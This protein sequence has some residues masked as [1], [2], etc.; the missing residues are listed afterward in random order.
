L[1]TFS[2]SFSAVSA[3]F[4]EISIA[5]GVPQDKQALRHSDDIAQIVEQLLKVRFP[6]LSS[7]F[8]ILTLPLFAAHS[9]ADL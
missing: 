9:G 8:P 2:S 5:L 6:S 4:L 1:L 7:S 3:L